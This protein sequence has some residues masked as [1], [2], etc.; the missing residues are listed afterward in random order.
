MDEERSGNLGERRDQNIHTF[1]LHYF[2]M[3][4]RNPFGEPLKFIQFVKMDM[5]FIE[6]VILCEGLFLGFVFCSTSI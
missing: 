3:K 5:V 6:E 2:F 1:I 4:D